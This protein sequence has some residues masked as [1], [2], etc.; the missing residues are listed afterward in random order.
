RVRGP[1]WNFPFRQAGALRARFGVQ[2]R[3]FATRRGTEAQGDKMIIDVHTHFFRPELDFGPSLRADLARCG[4]SPAAWGDVGERHL[5]TTME[6]DAAVVFGLQAQ[7]TGWN[8]P[9]DAVA[10]HVARAP[11]RLLFFTALDPAQPD[12]MAELERCHRS[13]GAVGVKL[14]PLYQNVHPRDPRCCDIYR[15]CVRH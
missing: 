9:N 14:A 12:C 2:T 15:Y 4:V 8:I 6:A 7:A 13:L 11:E 3:G 5:E 1:R 10:A